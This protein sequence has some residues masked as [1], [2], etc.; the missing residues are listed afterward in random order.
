MTDGDACLHARMPQVTS[1][2]AAA[3][4]GRVAV[5]DYHLGVIALAVEENSAAQEALDKCA[6]SSAVAVQ[7]AVQMKV[8]VEMEVQV[9]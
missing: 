9:V 8:K 3:A 1:A 6:V 5:I 4:A 2:A 7:V